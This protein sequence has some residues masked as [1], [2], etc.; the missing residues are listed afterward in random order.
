MQSFKEKYDNV[1]E[2]YIIDVINSASKE[3]VARIL[4]KD[5]LVWEDF[6]KLIS[7]AAEKHLHQFNRVMFKLLS[8]HKRY[9]PFVLIFN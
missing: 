7:P 8:R 4:D 2:Q 5:N 6:L 3:E 1:D 9:L